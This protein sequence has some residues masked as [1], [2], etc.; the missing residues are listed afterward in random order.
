[1]L[2]FPDC[3]AAP[4]RQHGSTLEAGGAHRLWSRGRV[5]GGAVLQVEQRR[6]EERCGHRR[7]DAASQHQL[8]LGAHRVAELQQSTAVC[9]NGTLEKTLLLLLPGQL[10]CV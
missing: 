1:M 5:A 2:C 8:P 3:Q 10:C 6:G 4:A 9:W 7:R